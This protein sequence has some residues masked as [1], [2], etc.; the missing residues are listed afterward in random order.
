MRVNTALAKIGEDLTALVQSGI[1]EV[2]LGGTGASSTMPLKQ[3]P[4][5]PSVLIALGHQAV[6]LHGVMAGTATPRH[7]RDGAAMMAEWMALPQLALGAAS[8]LLTA[9][10]LLSGLAPDHRYNDGRA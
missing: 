10:E 9:K 6:A 7:Q 3:N 1:S 2:K 8:G 4:V 5:A